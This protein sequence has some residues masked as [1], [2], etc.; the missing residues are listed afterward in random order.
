MNDW[1]HRTMIVA[2]QDVSLARSLCQSLAEG[3]A[4]KG[5]FSTP[6]SATGKLPATHYI[7]AGLIWP[8][9]AA[10][11]GDVQATFDAA[12]G[13]IPKATIQGMYTRATIVEE[14]AQSVMA[15]LG[16]KMINEGTV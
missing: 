10:L 14:E 2:A 3:D 11:L 7:S 15:G 6:L 16:L 12:G 13:A 9:M 5:M 1:T 8:V 4:G